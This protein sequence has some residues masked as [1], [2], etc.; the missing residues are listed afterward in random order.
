VPGFA[1]ALAARLEPGDVVATY[2]EALPS[3]VFYLR[4]HVDPYFEAEP[5]IE[6]F[7][8]GRTVYAIL[9]AENYRDLAP[10]L[11][12][13]T[14]V[15]DRRPTFDV[16]LKNMLAQQPLPELLLVTNKCPDR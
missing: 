8:S 5:L 10:T 9:S 16:K 14:C 6:R 11:G 15:I 7:R 4:R 2:D 12:L 3:L 13:R 1:Q